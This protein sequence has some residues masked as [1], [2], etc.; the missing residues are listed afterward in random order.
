ML[1]ENVRNTKLFF[2]EDNKLV[3]A[4]SRPVQ[5][6]DTVCLAI[7]WFLDVLEFCQSACV[8]AAV[9]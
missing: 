7:C 9:C 2:W 5:S 6:P 8:E 1:L 4:V 3:P